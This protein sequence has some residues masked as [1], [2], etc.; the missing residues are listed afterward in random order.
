MKI[1]IIHTNEILDLDAAF[2]DMAPER[3]E[4]CR[5]LASPQTRLLCVAADVAARRL[6][7]DWRKDGK[8]K[9]ICDDGYLS[10]AHS[11]EYAVAV[12]DEVLIGVDIEQIRPLSPA[13]SKRL[14]TDEP[15]MEWVKR[16]AYGKA[17]GVGVYR[18]LDDPIPEGWEF[19]FPEAPDGYVMVICRKQE[20]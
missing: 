1:E 8:G 15:L 18:V 10:L 9:P 20:P 4:S 7:G 11:G 12:W 16:E 3:Q 5:R 6:V 17:L 14:G 2:A 19:F 13:L